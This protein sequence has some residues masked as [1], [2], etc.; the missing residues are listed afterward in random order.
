MSEL[1]ASIPDINAHLPINVQIDNSVDDSLQVDAYRLIAG[2]L[3]EVFTTSIITTWTSP[4]NT[5]DQI[6]SIAGRLIASKYYAR[7][8]AGE[9]PDEIPPYSVSLYNQAVGLLSDIR[10]GNLTVIGIDGNPIVDPDTDTSEDVF[11]N[12]TS[13]PGPQFT[14]SRILS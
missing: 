14:M 6:R 10:A 12:D 13:T 7:L 3:V 4:E 9:T 11:P 2:Q 8:L 1:L 5:P